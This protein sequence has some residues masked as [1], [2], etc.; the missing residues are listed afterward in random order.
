[1]IT[2]L[3][4]DQVI[5]I[6]SRNRAGYL[7]E[8]AGYTLGLA[9]Q[10]GEALEELLPNGYL[11]EVT[12]A[13]GKV[14]EAYKDRT[15]SA[16]ES[17]DA[18]EEVNRLFRRAK[19]WRRAIVNRASRAGR[20]GKK[21]PDDLLK[22][23]NPKTVPAVVSLLEQMV[24]LAEANSASLHGANLESMIEE[25][26][27]LAKNIKAIDAEQEVRRLKNLPDAVKQ[28]H[29]EKGLL[30]IGVK[31]INEAGRELHAGSP[32]DA[33]KYNLSILY[34]NTGKKKEETAST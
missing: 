5:E 18:A 19:V 32:T 30:F 24:K 11:N 1:M 10:D 21:I 20:M 17:K 6:G 9:K 4:K 23:G 2:E 26:R 22:I 33:A 31:V 28:F 7:V 27:T 25:G 29:Y 14:S 12:K 34:R 8:Q 16:E 15:L 3:E 13:A